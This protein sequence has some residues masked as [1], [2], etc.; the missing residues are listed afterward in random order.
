[1]GERITAPNKNPARQQGIDTRFGTWNVRSLY[2]EGSLKTVATELTKCNSDLVAIRGQ[3]VLS[4]PAENFQFFH[5]S[6]N[7]KH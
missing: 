5:G 3:R 2:R 4:Q 6:L 1:L 7:A